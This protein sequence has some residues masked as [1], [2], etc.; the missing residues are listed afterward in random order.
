M[1]SIIFEPEDKHL[2]PWTC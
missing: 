2:E 1:T